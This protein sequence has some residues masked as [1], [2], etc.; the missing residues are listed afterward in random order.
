MRKVISLFLIV[1]S[2][3]L[4][5]NVKAKEDIISIEDISIEKKSEGVE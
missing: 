2:F 1:F 4:F 5:T 3:F